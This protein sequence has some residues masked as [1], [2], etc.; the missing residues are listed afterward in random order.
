M[1]LFSVMAAMAGHTLESESDPLREGSLLELR[2][3]TAGSVVGLAGFDGRDV[4]DRVLFVLAGHVHLLNPAYSSLGQD[5]SAEWL[6]RIEYVVSGQRIE[7]DLALP[8]T[9][10]PFDTLM[11]LPA[12]RLSYAGTYQTEDPYSREDLAGTKKVA[13]LPTATSS[14]SVWLYR[15]R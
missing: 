8:R 9:W 14:A 2:E 1:A 6:E 3:D 4:Q 15:V 11:T 13:D 5:V 7:G 10:Y 12:E